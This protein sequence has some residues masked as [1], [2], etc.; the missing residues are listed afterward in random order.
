MIQFWFIWNIRFH[1]T[2][3]FRWN[4]KKVL[5]WILES[6]IVATT[7]LFFFLWMLNAQLNYNHINSHRIIV[8]IL[9]W[10]FPFSVSFIEAHLPISDLNCNVLNL[11][12]NSDIAIVLGFYT[13]FFFMQQT[14]PF[15]KC[16][17][18]L[19]CGNV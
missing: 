4:H 16:I 6:G 12:S 8:I 13:K 1:G 15:H 19:Q 2:F 9:A 11:I 3:N 14:D 17:I 10:R 5:K 7:V 18:S